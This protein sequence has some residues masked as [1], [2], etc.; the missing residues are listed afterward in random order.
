[1]SLEMLIGVLIPFLNVYLH[2]LPLKDLSRLP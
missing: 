2:S 1:M